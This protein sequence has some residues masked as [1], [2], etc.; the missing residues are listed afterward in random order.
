MNIFFLSNSSWNLYN[1]RLNL[2]LSLLEKKNKIYILAPRDY[3]SKKLENIG[4]DFIEINFK[5]RSKSIISNLNILYKYFIII[6]KI[7]PEIILSYT[8]KP[9]IYGSLVAKLLKIKCI[10]TI[11]GL[12]SGF[13]NSKILSLFIIKLYKF[14][15]GK[16]NIIFFQNREDQNIFQTRKI[17][18]PNQKFKIVPGSGIDLKKFQYSQ[19]KQ[20]NNQ[21]NFLFVGRLIYEKGINELIESIK[22]IKKNFNNVNFKILGQC[23]NDITIGPNLNFIKDLSLKKLFDYEPFSDKVSKFI[24]ESDCLILPSYREGTSKVILEAGALGRPVIASNVPGINNIID[25][26]V[27]GFLINPKD[28]NSLNNSIIKFINLSKTSK[29]TMS[30]NIRKKIEKNFDEKFVIEEYLKNINY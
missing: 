6:N 19:L 1:F 21:T 12:G 18:K 20:E 24:T 5:S 8:I 4:C 2:I 27:D 3:Y 22:Y 10:V 16:E 28:V 26:N 15:F 14:S 9:N 17:L 23:Y 29:I 7:K 13:I 11:T 25:N 30:K